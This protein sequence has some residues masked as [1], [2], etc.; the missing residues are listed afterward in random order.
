MKTFTMI[1][2]C[3]RR[4]TKSYVHFANIHINPNHLI[5][6]D[7]YKHLFQLNKS[8]NDFILEGVCWRS[9]MEVKM[10]IDLFS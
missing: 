8:N 3:C 6:W 4:G 9:F 5:Y 1:Y 2:D 10:S 7:M